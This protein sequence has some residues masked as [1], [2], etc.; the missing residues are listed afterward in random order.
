MDLITKLLII[1]P[2]EKLLVEIA[3]LCFP[4]CSHISQYSSSRR[5]LCAQELSF[6]TKLCPD[7]INARTLRHHVY[8][9]FFDVLRDGSLSNPLAPGPY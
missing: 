4:V 9:S 6:P 8:D 5:R 1:P 2:R 3:Q 7:I